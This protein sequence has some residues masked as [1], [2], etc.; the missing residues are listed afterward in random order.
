MEIIEKQNLRELIFNKIS[1]LDIYGY[2]M[3][4]S[5][6]LNKLTKNPFLSKDR[7]PSFIIGN[8]TGDIIHKAFNSEH[9]GDCISFVMQM[10]DITYK[11]A[12]NKICFDFHLLDV[13]SVKYEK[14]IKN[15]PKIKEE[16][17][18][19]A[20][21]IAVKTKEFT[22]KELDYWKAYS[23]TIEDLKQNNIY[24]PKE[25]WVNYQKVPIL[26]NEL[27]F[28]YYYP[29]IQKWKIYRP[30]AD[31][32][33]KWFT[34]VPFD[35][36][37]GINK[38]TNCDIAFISKS[39]KDYMVLKKALGLDCIIISQAEDLSC[40]NDQ[41]IKILKKIKK[42]YTIFD[43]DKKGKESS[44]TLTNLFGFFHCNVPDK[45]LEENITDF[46]DL[47]KVYGIDKVTEHFKLKNII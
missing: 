46:A 22:Q 34:N 24:S 38:L 13:S 3:P 11:E 10:Y 21:H 15:L 5:F 7:N 4:H 35:Y 39:K 12:L 26:K 1:S 44:W 25:I 2:Y 36:I 42:V 27:I 41:T 6:S 31:K 23:I 33:K 18:K 17:V 19:K 20:P 8:K 40:F 45:Y 30:L 9:K 47:A 14:V 28:C 43:V 29:E 16:P 37:D 32:K